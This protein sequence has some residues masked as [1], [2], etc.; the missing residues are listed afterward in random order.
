MMR[1]L[2]IIFASLT[3][4]ANALGN[5]QADLPYGHDNHLT[6]RAND[7]VAAPQ[8]RP[9]GVTTP[10]Q[11]QVSKPASCGAQNATGR[12]LIPSAQTAV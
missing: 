1:L 10:V 4:V 2:T 7:P 12:S 8:A 5:A 11:E 9:S 6:N 3:T